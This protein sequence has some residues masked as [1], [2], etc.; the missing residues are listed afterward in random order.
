MPIGVLL[1]TEDADMTESLIPAAKNINMDVALS[2]VM[3]Q[4]STKG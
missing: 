3:R 4:H 2:L 1:Y